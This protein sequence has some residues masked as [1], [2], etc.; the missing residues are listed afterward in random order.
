M[1]SIL[2]RRLG[3]A[4]IAALRALNALFADTF[5]D[6]ETYAGDPPR[7]AW[8]AGLLAKEHIVVLVAERDREVVGGLVA[9]VFD[10]VER[11][12]RE[13]YIY[14][15]AVA[16]AHRRRGVATALIGHLR[17]IAAACGAW[18]VFVQAD[19]G[20]DPAIALY[21]KLGTREDVL[22]FDIPV[23]PAVP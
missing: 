17:G 16:E 6:R 21:G 18:V 13:I 9:Y 7:D 23:G 15:L 1:P 4:D 11:M 2:V 3:P 8:L 5:G 22:H 14:D 20:D 10:K 19:P 12:R